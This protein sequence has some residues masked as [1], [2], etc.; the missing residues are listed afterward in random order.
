M[1]WP[2]DSEWDAYG[3][4]GLKQPAGSTVES[5]MLYQGVY[6]VAMYNAGKDAYADLTSQIKKIT[7]ANA[8]YSDVKSGD[9]Q[10][11]EYQYGQHLVSIAVNFVDMEILIRVLR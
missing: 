5:V 3:L 1:V 11:T 6:I 4:K 9:G 8:P 7:G 2:A 10:L